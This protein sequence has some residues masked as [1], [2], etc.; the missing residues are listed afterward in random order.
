[1]NLVWLYCMSYL[2]NG[3]EFLFYR[4]SHPLCIV[5]WQ[6]ANLTSKSRADETVLN[7]GL[8]WV[9]YWC[10]KLHWSP[11]IKFSAECKACLYIILGSDTLKQKMICKIITVSLTYIR[12]VPQLE[13]H[14]WNAFRLETPIKG[15]SQ[16]VSTP[17]HYPWILDGLN[18]LPSDS[19]MLCLHYLLGYSAGEFQSLWSIVLVAFGAVD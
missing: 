13:D 9:S 10:V 12:T 1:M 7:L 11:L 17:G 2:L 6:I 18:T 8:G 3:I 16:D 14:W 15:N 5:Y 4:M 19:F